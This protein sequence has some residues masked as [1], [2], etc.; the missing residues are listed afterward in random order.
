M[1]PFS[2]RVDMHIKVSPVSK[3]SLAAAKG[4]GICMSSR[5]MR[6][7]VVKA[8]EVQKR[9]Y[10][11]TGFQDNGSLDDSGIKRFC[12]LKDSSKRMMNEAYDKMGLTMRGYKKILKIARTIADMDE[13]ETIQDTHIAEALMYRVNIEDI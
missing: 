3:D 4:T 8:R 1:G 6:E 2:D 5:E 9:R 7:M 10:K 12:A 13:S 11:G